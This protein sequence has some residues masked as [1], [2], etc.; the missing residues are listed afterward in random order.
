VQFWIAE[1]PSPPAVQTPSPCR[2]RHGIRYFGQGGSKEAD[3]NANA[4]ANAVYNIITN[5]R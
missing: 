4:N 2:K 1:G 3:A 5:A